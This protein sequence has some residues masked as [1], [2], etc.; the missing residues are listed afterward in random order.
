MNEQ[1]SDALLQKLDSV[2]NH[3]VTMIKGS[4]DSQKTIKEKESMAFI[5]SQKV[6]SDEEMNALQAK[7][8]SYKAEQEQIMKDAIAQAEAIA[9]AKAQEDLR[10]QAAADAARAQALF[11]AQQT[12]EKAQQAALIE[13]A[14]LQAE[15]DAQKA[16]NDAAA[17]EAAKLQAVK[18]A[19]AALDAALKQVNP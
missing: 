11:E 10:V 3:L 16:I 14:R 18:D 15:L 12:A 8:D 17:F 9:A 19:Q 2:L 1:Q 4:E 6:T 5:A 13:Q 7:I